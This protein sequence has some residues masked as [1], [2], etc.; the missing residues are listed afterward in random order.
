MKKPNKCPICGKP[1]SKITN[2]ITHSFYYKCSNKNC[3]FV[4]GEDYTEAE[5]YLQGT[6]L[7]TCCV[8]CG[9]PLKVVNGPH[10]LYARCFNCTCDFKPFRWEGKTFPKWVNAH[11]S[12]TKE[13]VVKLINSFNSKNEDIDQ[14]FDFD[15]FIAS[16]ASMKKHEE[17]EES[18]NNEKKE[19]CKEGTISER[20]LNILR[21]NMKIPQSAEGLHNNTGIPVCSIRL[22]MQPLRKSGKIKVVDYK[23]NKGNHTLFYQV[24]ESPIKALDIY[25]RED[26]YN[27]VSGFLEEEGLSS[28]N[29]KR[30]T[31]TAALRKNKVEPV[32]FQNSR[33]VCN[34]YPIAVMK[35][36]LN[37]KDKKLD[38]SS[39]TK[40][41][42]IAPC[43]KLSLQKNIISI[44]RENLNQSFTSQAIADKLNFSV[45]SVRNVIKSLRRA[46]KIK[47]VGWKYREGCK[48]AMA[49]F[50]QL[51]ESPLPR[52]K[53]TVDNNAYLTFRQ[54][55]NKKLRG[56]RRTSMVEASK[57]AKN[58][59]V[60]P[61][62]LNERAYAGYSVAD[63]KEAF[64][65][66]LDPTA[67]NKNLA[68]TNSSKKS[69]KT[70]TLT[71]TSNKNNMLGFFSSLFKKK[72]KVKG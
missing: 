27:S 13:E 23:P 65:K 54:F 32:V 7:N 3:P 31:L 67:V 43:D 30:L 1:I 33:N 70:A 44:L 42:D 61:L 5:L 8:G 55:Y 71:S 50:Y 46:R 59:L 38:D 52:L 41:E 57:I 62:I 40:L 19:I 35:E 60:T 11:R 6:E 29:S 34:G 64:K 16:S 18:K 28:L 66:Y 39:L 53:V 37:P 72:D 26:G 17:Y 63:L 47:I 56:K 25:T 68:R 51:P 10:G 22:C 2:A 12:A 21:S 14:M 69:D 20:I 58:L 15:K 49:L 45:I 48:G 4:L 36:L 24:S 9:A